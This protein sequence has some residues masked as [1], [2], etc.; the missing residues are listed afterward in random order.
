MARA[1]VPVPGTKVGREPRSSSELRG[2]ALRLA[3][4]TR[5]AFASLRPCFAALAIHCDLHVRRD[6]AVQL[7]RHMEFAEALERIVEVNLAT[8]DVE[9]L[10]FER[11]RDLG[12]SNGSEEVILLADFALERKLHIV[13]LLRES[14]GT[15]LFF[16]RLADGCSLHLLD[17]SLVGA[18][19]FN[20]K[21][22][23][24]KEIAAVSFGDFHD[25]AAMAELFDI[26]FE[27]D[28]HENKLLAASFW[29]PATG[30]I[31]SAPGLL[32][33]SSR[34]FSSNC[35]T[36]DTANRFPEG[37]GSQWLVASSVFT[38]LQTAAGRCCAPA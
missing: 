38:L 15:G 1:R 4:L 32:R 5:A 33:P 17:D 22:A 25:L 20:G 14:F 9:A 29:L 19:C 28:F 23:R 27:N 36:G 37:A 13:E 21:L 30:Q 16:C 12:G 2:D 18:A 8:I 31:R 26:F 11:A 7:D 10:C 35:C 24:Q 34:F 6:F 3:S